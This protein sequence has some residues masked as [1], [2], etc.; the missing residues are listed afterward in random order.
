MFLVWLL[1]ACRQ[2]DVGII[3]LSEEEGA[4]SGVVE[5][6]LDPWVE[7][8]SEPTGEP[9]NEMTDLTIGYG[10]IHFKQI[11]CPAC[12]GV[13]NEFDISATLDLHQPTS[14]DY[15]E[16]LTPVG[17]CTT[18]L[19]ES[20]VSSQ[21]LATTSPAYFNDIAL[22]P[23]GQGEWFTNSIYEYQYQR[24]TSYNVTSE[25]GTIQNAFRTV[26]GFDSIEPYTML[27]V[28][29]SYAFEAVISKQGTYLSWSPAVNGAQF[30]VLIAVYSP[31][32]SQ[33][34]GMVSCMENDVGY[35][36]VPGSYFQAYPTW[37]L[38]AIYL[39]RHR[40]GRTP[41]PDFNGY[42]ESH[43]TWT[44]LGTGHIE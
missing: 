11:A 23:A 25:H 4:D 32:G 5:D 8:T 30:E 13:Y 35:L 29:P 19:I 43:Q 20:Y 18:N 21:P 27:W 9:S 6:K 44:V 7:P 37:A 3:K 40:T 41:A 39:T 10:E 31:D 42:L 38:T 26:E 15:N 2:G 22:Q 33:L 34:R 28:D 12:V 36:T 14:G 17:T 1:L 24:N 16:W